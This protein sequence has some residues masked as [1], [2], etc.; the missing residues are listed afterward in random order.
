MEKTLINSLLRVYHSD[1]L[2]HS[3]SGVLIRFVE[4]FNIGN[5]IGTSLEFS[6]TDRESI[7][8][9]LLANEGINTK[10]TQVGQ[11]DGLSRTESL[12]YSDNEKM[13]SSSVR[14]G[15]VAIKALPGKFLH[16][17]G[18]SIS[19]PIGA[20]L[21]LH[22]QWIVA[23]CSHTSVL[24]VENW[25]AF[26][27]IHQITFD[28]SRAGENPLVVFRGSPVYRQDYAMALLQGLALPV[29]T[30][31]DYDPSGL[32][33][34]Q[35]TPHFI[36]LMTPP[37]HELVSALKTIKNYSRYRSQL[38]QAQAV[39]NNST[40][41]DIVAHWKLLQEHGTALPQEY[42]LLKRTPVNR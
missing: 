27:T 42:F 9:L 5:R 37:T 11:W 30:L 28:L 12:E 19:M 29:F 18:Q 24:L 25:E 26:D 35:S 8:K 1:K 32:I 40:H 34:A 23:H 21:D 2:R 41:P 16:I 14:Q 15:R 10:T 22:W 39:L 31:V 13:T 3:A 4:D 7:R 20:N 33:L 38:T 6:N 17:D 36:G